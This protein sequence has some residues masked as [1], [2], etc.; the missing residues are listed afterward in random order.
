MGAAEGG[1]VTDGEGF[2]RFLSEVSGWVASAGLG[3]QKSHLQG[4]LT[5][6]MEKGSGGYSEARDRI[7]VCT[8]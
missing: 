7:F 4:T 8:L 3:S 1:G 2:G 6:A 5:W